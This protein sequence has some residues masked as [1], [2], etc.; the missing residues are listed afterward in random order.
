M[1]TTN[2]L[3]A[4]FLFA[5]DDGAGGSG[6]G[7]GDPPANNDGRAT[8]E[9][10]LTKQS[11]DVRKLYEEHTTGL[12]SALE[13]ERKANKD[14]SAAV[15]K[16]KELEEAEAKRKQAELSEMEKLKAQLAETEAK[17]R[18][19]LEQHQK[20]MIKSAVLMA[21]TTAN[22]QKPEDAYALMDLSMVEI[23]DEDKVTGVKEALEALVKER[24]YLIKSSK[25][26]SVNIDATNKGGS[27][28]EPDDKRKAEL[29]QRFRLRPPG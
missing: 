25:P 11:D 20:G 8:W 22:F 14:S 24:P 19:A 4:R 16:L 5:P 15:K 18:T 28:G 7:S 27:G 17:H 12:K 6:G 10:W 21:A 26:D 9:A 29:A 23:S 13:S 2:Q 3:R 1:L